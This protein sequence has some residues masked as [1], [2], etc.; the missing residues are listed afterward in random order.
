MLDVVEPVP[1]AVDPEPVVDPVPE[2][3]PVLEPVPGEPGT[4][5]PDELP[6]PT[7]IWPFVKSPPGSPPP[8]P[9]AVDSSA[10]TTTK[11][12]AA[13][14]DPEAPQPATYFTAISPRKPHA[15]CSASGCSRRPP[16]MNA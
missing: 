16:T 4:G 8:P 2:V 9:Q 13:A 14:C 12:L 15:R 11:T 7:V 6:P 10:A 1:G 5:V 3:V